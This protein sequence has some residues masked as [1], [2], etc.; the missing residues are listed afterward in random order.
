MPGWEVSAKRLGHIRP[1]IDAPRH[2]SK[3]LLRENKKWAALRRATT[4]DQSA[5]KCQ[6]IGAM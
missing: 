2:N 5:G 3:R 1:H 4:L 6:A